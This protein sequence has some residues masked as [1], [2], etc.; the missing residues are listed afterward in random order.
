MNVL[1]EYQV[2]AIVALREKFTHGARRV[3]LMLPTGAGKTTIASDMVRKVIEKSSLR[4]LFVVDRIELINQTSERFFLDGID[5][6]VIQAQHPCYDPSKQVQVCSIQTLARRKTENYGLLIIDECHT[7]HRAHHKLIEANPTGFVVGLSATPF[8]KGMGKV[9]DDL[10]YPISA[11]E[12]IEQK[13]LSDFQAYGPSIDLSGIKTV[14]GDY[15]PEQLGERVDTPKLVADV[16]QTWIKRA[17]GRRTI[18]FATNIAHSKHL[19]REFC[20]HGVIAEHLDCYTGKDAESAS[21]KEVIDRFRSGETM[22][23]CNVD[24]LGKGFDVPEVSCIIQA[25]PTKSLM[26]HIQQVGRGLRIA[27]DKNE[28]IILD[29]A[30]N[31]ERLGFIDGDLPTVLDGREKKFGD[32]RESEEKEPAL[33]KPCPSCD[34]LKPAGV[35]KCPACG[36]VPEYIEDVE[37]ASGE[38]EKLQRTNRKKYTLPEKQSFMAQLNQYAFEKG[39][40]RGRGGCYGWAIHKYSEKMGGNPPSHIDWGMREPVGEEV[41]KWIKHINIRN[42]KRAEKRNCMTGW[43][44]IP[45]T[46]P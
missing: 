31:H 45:A 1:R 30:S 3:V 26:V 29:H 7:L 39:Y 11:K 25:R 8:A 41:R 16:V 18:C 2:Q 5:H 15:D 9:F 46:G 43:N 33:P 12:L 40:R 13:Y 19:T 4:C 10:V 35:R 21:R 17:A 6:G 34:F 14:R 32:S 27:P 38:L 44:Q 42:A 22:V 23:L 24:I 37:T 36:L 28:C 20:K